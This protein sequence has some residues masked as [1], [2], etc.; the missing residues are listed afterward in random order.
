MPNDSY[1]DIFKSRSRYFRLAIS[2]VSVRMWAEYVRVL[3]HITGYSNFMERIY[4]VGANNSTADRKNS[5][6]WS[7]SV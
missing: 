5:P 4:S 1:S 6:T 3:L 2:Y 7:S